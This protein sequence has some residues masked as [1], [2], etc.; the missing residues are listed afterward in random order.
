[1]V[2]GPGSGSEPSSAVEDGPSSGSRA[3]ALSSTAC[4]NSW[5]SSF[6]T[7]GSSAERALT[8]ITASSIRITTYH[9]ALLFENTKPRHPLCSLI[10]GSLLLLKCPRLLPAFAQRF[11]PQEHP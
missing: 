10:A 8:R 11:E 1:M 2:S 7:S 4:R 3:K 6:L 9:D 5:E